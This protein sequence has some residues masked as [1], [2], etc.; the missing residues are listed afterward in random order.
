MSPPQRTSAALQH[1]GCALAVLVPCATAATLRGWTSGVA[2]SP[3]AV[4]PWVQTAG[5]QAM[6]PLQAQGQAVATGA[7]PL[8]EPL[9]PELEAAPWLSGAEGVMGPFRPAGGDPRGTT[10]WPE[11]QGG[12]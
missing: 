11:V 6:A 7:V 8:E 3:H 2:V 10:A 5:P 4:W 9:A 1:R 12:V